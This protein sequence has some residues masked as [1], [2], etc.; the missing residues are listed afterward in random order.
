M[1][2]APSL[3][4][5]E[6]DQLPY[7]SMPIAYTQPGS[8]AA[9]ATLFGAT[10]RDAETAVVLELG[11]ASGGNIIP[12]A[13]RFPRARFLGVDLSARHVAEANARIS[14]L[15]L[16]NINIRQR[17]IGGLTFEP[18]SFDF[19]VCHGVF[20][21]V[22]R[23]VQDSIL[24]ICGES[25]RPGGVAAVSYNVLPGWHMRRVVRDILMFHADPKLSP[26]DRV[27]K[28]RK[29]LI[30][31]AGTAASSNPY[32]A[33]LRSEAERLAKAPSAYILGEFLV[34]QNA[35][36]YFSEF[37]ARAAQSGLSYLCDGE[38][39]TSLPEY[40]APSVAK[41]VREMA[42]DSALALQQYTDLFTGRPFRR[43]LLVK[44]ADAP[45][46]TPAVDPAR[47]RHLHFAADLRL[48]AERSKAGEMVYVDQRN[49]PIRPK[50]PISAAVVEGLASAYPGTRSLDELLPNRTAASEAKALQA[51]TLLLISEQA[52]VSTVPLR[53][54]QGD[55][56]KPR[57]W[58]LARL[59]AAAQQPWVTAMH[60]VPVLLSAPVL[61]LLP[62]LNGST[63][64]AGLIR[65]GGEAFVK[66]EQP[67]A[68]PKDMLAQ[69]LATAARQGLLEP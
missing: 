28:A 38:V 59:E 58:G 23:P 65:L 4:T 14:A 41:R 32:I 30:E 56:D 17:D 22:P 43:S 68:Q 9:M 34:E 55:G 25:L 8:L 35:P 24:R 53:V 66:A 12:L 13:M 45:K 62:H 48:R 1:N 54:G 47:A 40:F 61:Q 6:Y 7:P 15:G 3:A 21:W 29:A 60:H 33:L 42:H 57:V 26:Q 19:I 44:A 18:A 2:G 11:C 67:M 20:S 51:L 64:R 39:T 63:D 49:R 36:C 31:I 5:V 52:T 10:P 37:A 16:K 46:A 27:N 50:G 69:A